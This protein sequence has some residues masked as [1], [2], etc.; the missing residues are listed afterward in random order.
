MSFEFKLPNIGEGVQGGEIVRLPVKE[1]DS[2]RRDQTI[3][4]V[5]TDKATMEITSPVSGT[6]LKI[7]AGEGETVEVGQLII[8]LQES[9]EPPESTA[10]HEGGLSLMSKPG[11]LSLENGIIPEIKGSSGGVDGSGPPMEP[12][13]ME[14]PKEES[15]E[16]RGPVKALPR[17]RKLARQVGVDMSLVKGTGP[18]GRVTDEDIRAFAGRLKENPYRA[19][20]TVE[21]SLGETFQSFTPPLS[22]IP[23]K[24]IPLTGLSKKIAEN[25]E[26]SNR[27]VPRAVHFDELDLTELVHLRKSI[28]SRAEEKGIKLTYL[29]FFVKAAARALEEHP[30]INSMFDE[31]DRSI[32]QLGT[33]D[34][35]IAVAAESGLVV[36]IVREVNRK[37]LSDIAQEIQRLAAAAGEGRIT[38]GDLKGGGFVIINGGGKGGM[39]SVPLTYHP[40]AAILGM[41]TITPRP[42]VRDRGIVVA[43][44]M[45]I[46]LAYDH[47]I[48]DGAEIAGFLAMMK[49]LLENPGIIMMDMM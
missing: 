46:S 10:R 25:M 14:S 39:L 17:T 6:V 48:V 33:I 31:A 23:G 49:E 9:E 30:R 47:R 18:R 28:K 5:M 20:D 40:R 4:E 12:G 37:S 15:P 3:L 42:V 35:G 8:E 41:H 2:V 44:I 13:G 27:Y 32:V 7:H 26:L 16:S 11:F 45:Y 22:S 19:P 24:K 38:A 29:S 21:I 43:D 1:G 34:V 36:P